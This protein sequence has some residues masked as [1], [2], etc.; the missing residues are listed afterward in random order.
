MTWHRRQRLR[1]LRNR[2]AAASFDFDRYD[3][4]LAM[5]SAGCLI[6]IY[7]AGRAA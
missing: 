3:L 6:G 7:L 1:R 5:L 4:G 2:I